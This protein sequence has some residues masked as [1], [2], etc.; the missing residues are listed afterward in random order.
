MQNQYKLLKFTRNRL[1]LLTLILLG[2]FSTASAQ[3]E[4]ILVTGTVKDESGI[5]LP[6]ANVIEKGT[7]NG[8]VTN[9]DG[10]VCLP[11]S[12]VYVCI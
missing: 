11:V 3:E 1:A 12:V 2:I 10:N 4:T 5:P 6:G 8:T 9:F 7:S